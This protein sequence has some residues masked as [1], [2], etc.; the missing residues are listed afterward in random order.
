[1]TRFIFTTSLLLIAQVS[2][3]QFLVGF[4]EPGI[5]QWYR[6][7]QPKVALS[8]GFDP[9]YPT[10]KI[11]KAN[12]DGDVFYYFNREG[13]CITA[14]YK[15]NTIAMQNGFI[16]MLNQNG[17]TI[18]R[19]AVWQL[20][21]NEPPLNVVKNVKAYET[22][23]MVS[24]TAPGDVT[25]GPFQ[26]QSSVNWSS[27]NFIPTLPPDQYYTKYEIAD[28]AKRINFPFRKYSADVMETTFQ[29]LSP[30]AIRQMNIDAIYACAT[31]HEAVKRRYNEV[32][33]KVP[34]ATFNR[35]CRLFC[36]L[37]KV[38]DEL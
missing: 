21:D 4:S 11:L 5:K 26:P 7:H 36:M 2:S 20:P 16:E 35:Y 31:S 13:L 1:M 24:R 23:F 8:K 27:L 15:P 19:D 37:M 33:M 17:I 9:E 38:E 34:E 30:A 32:Y 12:Q 28:F 29:R 10:I 6:D 22:Y 18:V 25:S 3:A 14:K